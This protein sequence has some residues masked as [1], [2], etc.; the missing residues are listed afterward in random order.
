MGPRITPAHGARGGG[1]RS[2]SHDTPL[3]GIDKGTLEL[4]ENVKTTSQFG[5]GLSA[6]SSSFLVSA[7]DRL[8]VPLQE[9]SVDET[10]VSNQ[11]F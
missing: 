2:A 6:S 11:C 10:R 9:S 3:G 1:G 7:P 5:A 8:T 4:S